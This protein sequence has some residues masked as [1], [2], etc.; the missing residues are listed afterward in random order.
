MKHHPAILTGHEPCMTNLQN[1]KIFESLSC[2]CLSFSPLH[3]QYIVSVATTCYYSVL[4]YIYIYI[5]TYLKIYIYNIYIQ[6]IYTIYIY[7]RELFKNLPWRPAPQ[8]MAHPLSTC[9]F[10]CCSKSCESP[11]QLGTAHWKGR[12]LG[13][14]HVF[15]LQKSHRFKLEAWRRMCHDV[16]IV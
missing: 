12:H 8:S 4:S 13:R 9:S 16:G 1:F 15:L 5:H 7:M 14:K 10:W 6:Y 11:K 3:V 2:S